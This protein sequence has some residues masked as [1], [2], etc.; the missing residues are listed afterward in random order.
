LWESDKPK[1]RDEFMKIAFIY[2][3]WFSKQK[4]VMKYFTSR[5][6]RLPVLGLSY[7]AAISEKMGHEVKIID[8]A[9]ENASVKGVISNVEKFGADIVG[10]SCSTP[11]SYLLNDYISEIKRRQF[12]PVIVE[13]GPHVTVLK[14]KALTDDVDFAFIG[15]AEKSWFN[16]LEEYERG[17]DFSKVKGLFYKDEDEKW[18]F[19][20][21]EDVVKDLDSIPFP[22][23]HL[24]KNEKYLINT[25]DGKQR[26]TGAIFTQ[27]G[28]PFK[29]IFCNT[30][31]TGGNIRRRSPKKVVEEIKLMIANYGVEHI[32]FLDETF[33]MVRK[34]VLELCDLLTREAFGV[35]F[36]IAT[37][38]N[39]LDDELVEKMVSAGLVRIG[40]GLESA[41][42]RV[43]DI[44]KKEVPLESYDAAREYAQKYGVQLRFSTIIGMPGDTIE[45]IRKTFRYLRFAPDVEHVSITIATPYP[46]TE[47]YDMAKAGKY[48]L[49]LLQDDF[50]KFQRYG[51]AVMENEKLSSEELVR[52]QDDCYVSI[53]M[54]PHRWKAIVN[55]F[56]FIGVFMTLKRFRRSFWRLITNK[57]G[58]FWFKK[59][60]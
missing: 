46:G 23:R 55:T 29:C 60:L 22:A 53:C 26:V 14:E 21:K 47:L 19:S 57:N 52:L 51:S 4:G 44:M 13:G 11:Y 15:E 38:A 40:I 50:S 25:P 36:E 28:C 6:A 58:L 3:A 59:G 8:A 30:E 10:I 41:D 49:K 18:V 20:G 12:N 31:L 54:L 32:F 2:P 5:A 45:S 34:H 35:T 9:I 27:R 48:G 42:L 17:K 37:R 24:L 16:F 56:G 43:R 1:L 7:L 39:L 33:T